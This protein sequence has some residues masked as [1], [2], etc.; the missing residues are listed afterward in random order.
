MSATT[1]GA[2]YDRINSVVF[3]QGYLRSKDPFSFEYQP[4]QALDAC[5]YVEMEQ[6]T[7]DGYSGFAQG[8]LHRVRV[9]VARRVRRDPHGARRQLIADL[10]LLE[11]PLY[12]DYA[13][14]GYH[15]A[16]DSVLK[17]IPSPLDEWDYAVGMLE[18]IVDF[19]RSLI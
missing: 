7:T 13:N 9:W 8:E 10:E 11:V 19:D 15:V 14:F 6:D 2:V 5:F 3:G 1:S 17:N 18:L 16:D 12:Q 4:R